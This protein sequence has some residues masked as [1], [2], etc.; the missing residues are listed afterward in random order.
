MA[1][2]SI[3]ETLRDAINATE[4]PLRSLARETGVPHPSIIRFRRGEQSL[5][6]DHADAIAEFFN[7][8]LKPAAKRRAERTKGK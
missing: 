1:R 4:T 5:R 7:L 8:E 2:K 3:T 6:L